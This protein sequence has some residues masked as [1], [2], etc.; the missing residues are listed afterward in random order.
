MADFKVAK[1]Q[2]KTNCLWFLRFFLQ[3]FMRHLLNYN[4]FCCPV[5]SCVQL[6][7]PFL[8][9]LWLDGVFYVIF[10]YPQVANSF[11]NLLCPN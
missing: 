10:N 4:L 3:L 8:K 7:D 1:N 9:L 11:K 5:Q 6:S 2:K